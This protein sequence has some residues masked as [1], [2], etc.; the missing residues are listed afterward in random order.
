MTIISYIIFNLLFFLFFRGLVVGY[1]IIYKKKFI[2]DQ[3]N[4]FNLPVF[5]FNQV[6]SLF[7]LGNLSIIL[8]FFFPVKELSYIFLGFFLFSILLNFYEKFNFDN[9][10]FVIISFLIVPSILSLSSYGLKLHFDAID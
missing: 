3:I 9:L 2:V 8:N 5:I 6:F 7:I 4:L 10:T 1:K